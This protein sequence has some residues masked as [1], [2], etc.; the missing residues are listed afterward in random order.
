MWTRKELKTRGKKA[1]LFNYWK[2]VLVSFILLVLVSGAAGSVSGVGGGR[3]SKNEIQTSIE[4]N[5]AQ[6]EAGTALE[7]AQLSMGFDIPKEAAPIIAVIG[8]LAG[9]V[10]IA[11]V[12]A[13]SAFLI[14]PIEVGCK[15]FFLKNLNQKASVSE[16]TYA[17]DNN[18]L[19]IVKTTLLRDIYTLLW[20]LLFIIPGIIKSYEYRLIPYLLADNPEMTKDEAFARSKELM[21]GQKW[22]TFVLDL[23]FLG[24]DILSLFT[25][26]ILEMLYVGPYKNMTEAA[27][28]ERLVYGNLS[29]EAGN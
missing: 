15:R 19:N 20:G 23:S 9:I 17:F 26:R 2:T 14:N 3:N 7:Q 11:V 29:E 6:S 13:V 25:A 28:Y 10:I 1:F 12:L 5:D 22:R 18:Y 4:S 21:K 27:L 8:G 24:W 16:I